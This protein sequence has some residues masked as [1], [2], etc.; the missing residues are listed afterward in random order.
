MVE[1]WMYA[2]QVTIFFSSLPQNRADAAKR[3][4]S[5]CN[6]FVLAF[7]YQWYDGRLSFLYGQ[8]MYGVTCA[9][10]LCD[11]KCRLRTEV[12]GEARIRTCHNVVDET[13]S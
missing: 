8:R 1:G 4:T 13:L 3:I 9:I 10:G 6:L 12:V 2:L 5:G 7:N 11:L